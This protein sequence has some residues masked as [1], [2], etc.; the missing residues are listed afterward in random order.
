MVAT[1]RLMASGPARFRW[2]VGPP[3]S[4]RSAGLHFVLLC[5]RVKFRH[6]VSRLGGIFAR[7][8]TGDCSMKYGHRILMTLAGLLLATCRIQSG[9][10]E[11][12]PAAI[13]A[14][15]ETKRLSERIEKSIDWY[16]L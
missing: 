6:S 11:D 10:A 14:Q 3:C 1:N 5:H 2:D 9:A 12:Q 7:R 15:E 16:E 4:M 8:Q 13:D